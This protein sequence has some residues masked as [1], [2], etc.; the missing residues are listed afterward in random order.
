MTTRKKNWSKR[1]ERSING[2]ICNGGRCRCSTKCVLTW[3]SDTSRPMLVYWGTKCGN[4]HYTKGFAATARTYVRYYWSLKC[5][6]CSLPIGSLRGFLVIE[7]CTTRRRTCSVVI[8]LRHFSRVLCFAWDTCSCW[9]AGCT[10][11]GRSISRVHKTNK[12]PLRWLLY[13]CR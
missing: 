4:F 2:R 7:L 6:H 1:T 13:R 3:M 11:L 8:K 5:S 9:C 10:G 12:N